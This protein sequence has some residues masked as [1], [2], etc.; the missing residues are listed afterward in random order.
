MGKCVKC[1]TNFI[2]TPEHPAKDG[3]CK[4]CEIEQLKAERDEARA[5][6]A[7]MPGAWICDKCGFIVQKNT[8]H[9]ADGTVSANVADECEGCPNDGSPLRSL[10]W[11]EANR[12]FY[13]DNLRLRLKLDRLKIKSDAMRDFIQ[14]LRSQILSKTKSTDEMDALLSED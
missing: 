9:V 10:T 4:Y 1:G 7:T 14:R 6:S 2:G 12:G 8:L 3:L 13:E 5:A 11:R